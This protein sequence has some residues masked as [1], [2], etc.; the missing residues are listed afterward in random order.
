VLQATVHEAEA[1]DATNTTQRFWIPEGVKYSTVSYGDKS[2]QLRPGELNKDTIKAK[3]ATAGIDADATVTGQGTRGDPFVV[4]FQS[5]AKDGANFRLLTQRMTTADVDAALE[6]IGSIDLNHATVTGSGTRADP[7]AVTLS[8]ASEDRDG[9][10][11][12][13]TEQHQVQSFVGAVAPRD[14]TRVFD[15]L[16]R[17]TDNQATY[18]FNA[19]G[20]PNLEIV[21]QAATEVRHNGVQQ[22]T[23]GAGQANGILWYGASGVAVGR[24]VTG[25]MVEEWLQRFPGVGS[26]ELTGLGDAASPWK[27]TGT[28]VDSTS[29]AA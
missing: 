22:L 8:G 26:V 4:K 23:L 20:T 24:E 11:H 9:N 15:R 16:Y 7:W 28:L 10:F 3:L 5:A 1:L 13:L 25:A 18:L 29:N 6:S 17:L 21:S 14:D 2:F 27:F 12:T 19:D